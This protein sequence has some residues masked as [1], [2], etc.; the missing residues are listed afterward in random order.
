MIDILFVTN[1]GKRREW[2]KKEERE[3][4]KEMVYNTNKAP[5]PPNTLFALR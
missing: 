4:V 1:K 2:Q 5:Q 3:Q